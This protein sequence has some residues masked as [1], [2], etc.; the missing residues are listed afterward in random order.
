MDIRI[1]LATIADIPRIEELI[2]LSV[3]GLSTDFYTPEQITSGLLHIFGVDTQLIA[4]E[5]YFLAEVGEKL[6]GSGGWSKRK[7][8][9]GGD[10]TKADKEDALLD[11]ASEAAR[12]RAFYVDPRWSRRGIAT[13]ILAA[14]EDAAQRS[15]FTKIELAATLPGEPFYS[16][17]GYRKAEAMRLETPSGESLPAFRMTKELL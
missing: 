3:S 5:T 13:R 6:V 12:V 11:T 2:R 16:S 14:C 8:L 1:R 7:T 10:Q 9:F 4:D 15:G 17:R